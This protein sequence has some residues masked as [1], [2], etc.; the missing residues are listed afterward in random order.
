[1]SG[2]VLGQHME[3]PLREAKEERVAIADMRR[4]CAIEDDTHLNLSVIQNTVISYHFTKLD[5][6]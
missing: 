1:M 3:R 6:V 5:K 4:Q 2:R